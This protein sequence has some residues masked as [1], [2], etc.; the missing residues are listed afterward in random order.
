MSNQA[1]SGDQEVTQ[2]RLFGRDTHEL[3]KSSGFPILTDDD[4]DKL[5]VCLAALSLIRGVGYR[6]IRRL[7]DTGVLHQLAKGLTSASDA[8]ALSLTQQELAFVDTFLAKRDKML[9]EGASLVD[10]LRLQNIWFA[11][12]G[13]PAYPPRLMRLVDAPR[14]IYGRGEN[15]VLHSTSVVAVV[16]TR[17]AGA[18]GRNLAYLCAAELVRRNIVVLSGLPVETP[19]LESG[20]GATIRRAISIGTPLV[21]IFPRGSGDKSL[22]ATRANLSKLNIPVLEVMNSESNEF[23]NYLAQIMPD[24]D[25]QAGAVRRQ[26]RLIRHVVEQVVSVHAKANLDA[27]AIQRLIDA[28]RDIPLDTGPR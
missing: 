14:W 22:L 13:H 8:P 26:D 11:P 21:G 2:G 25:W 3:P 4:R 18:N 19:S 15:Q 23:W 6:T 17:D 9:Q 10:S 1:D 12:L 20:T 28:L 16:G 5:H 24:H 7:W 27:A